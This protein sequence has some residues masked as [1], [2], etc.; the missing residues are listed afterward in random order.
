MTEFKVGDRVFLSGSSW[1]E[2]FSRYF[3]N[4]LRT[5]EGFAECDVEEGVGVVPYFTYQGIK[6]FIYRN[7]HSDYSAR[8]VYR[9]VSESSDGPVDYVFD[10][11]HI[12]NPNGGFK[13]GDRVRVT[14][15]DYRDVEGVVDSIA[16]NGYGVILDPYSFPLTFFDTCLEPVSSSAEEGPV[17]DAVNPSHYVFPGNVQVIDITR[18]LGFLEG[19]AV[20][21]LCRAGRKGDR[22]EDLKKARKY[23]DYAIEDLEK[24]RS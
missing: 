16:T 12:R 24:P 9:P 8:L 17:G 6:T 20:K 10:S 18:H 13:V 5:I 11:K 14:S 1:L 4:E 22:L 23:L 21:Y 15:S 7:E 3:R 19:N 2:D